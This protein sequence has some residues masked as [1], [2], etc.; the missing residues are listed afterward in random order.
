MKY[1]SNNFVTPA[2]QIEVEAI[3]DETS[4]KLEMSIAKG[5]HY[6]MDDKTAVASILTMDFIREHSLEFENVDLATAHLQKQGCD[7][8]FLP[9]SM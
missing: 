2:G 5:H 3:F 4:K 8:S 7:V 9:F 6:P 1:V